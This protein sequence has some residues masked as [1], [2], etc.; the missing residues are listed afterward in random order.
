MKSISLV[1]HLTAQ[2]PPH[3]ERPA[4]SPFPKKKKRPL[5]LKTQTWCYFDSASICT[6]WYSGD[7]DLFHPLP[8][9]FFFLA[10]PQNCC[11]LPNLMRMTIFLSPDIITIQWSPHLNFTILGVSF[12]RQRCFSMFNRLTQTFMVFSIVLIS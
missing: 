10:F 12:F 8:T 11:Y 2:M 1:T 9:S 6:P 5:P 4:T 3:K 7:D